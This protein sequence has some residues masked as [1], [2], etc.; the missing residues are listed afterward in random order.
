M[1]L[2]FTGVARFGTVLALYACS[3]IFVEKIDER[4]GGVNEPVGWLAVFL[5]LVAATIAVDSIILISRIIWRIESY[6][7]SVKE[8]ITSGTLIGIIS[9]WL[10]WTVIPIGSAI[11]DNRSDKIS[12]FFTYSDASF[13]S[14]LAIIFGAI[15]SKTLSL[16]LFSRIMGR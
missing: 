12:L 16:V 3:S 9:I 6:G 4:F 11:F 13:V 8:C 14:A 10:L 1:I 2:N 15:V 5:T 7:W